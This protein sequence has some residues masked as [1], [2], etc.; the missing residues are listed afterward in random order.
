MKKLLSLAGTLALFASMSQAEPP[1]SIS[2]SGAQGFQGLADY[3]IVRI[4]SARDV[5]GV[6]EVPQAV[7]AETPGALGNPPGGPSLIGATFA[8]E[9]NQGTPIPG[10]SDGDR[11]AACGLIAAEAL[12]RFFV[13]NPNLDQVVNIRNTAAVNGLWDANS[14][15]HGPAAEQ[16]LLADIGL[17]V[18]LN[19]VGD[20]NRAQQ[21]IIQ[22]LQRGKPVIIST[23]RHYFF[24]EG[25]NNGLFF[26]GH[27]GEVM[28][29]YG[30]S[31]QMTL[32]QISQAGNGSV[33][34]LIP[35]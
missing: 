2:V 4:G 1:E 17:Q 33:T 27:T 15:M 16:A 21:T 30:G 26:V 6:P 28:G 18:D 11:W 29:N 14:G 9:R 34:L 35:R 22:S 7:F 31:S 8:W 12:D 3:R 20:L 24:A 10:M 23:L 13:K 32:W 5:P 19:Q 25:Y